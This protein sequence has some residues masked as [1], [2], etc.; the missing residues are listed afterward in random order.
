MFLRHE[1]KLC[2][3]S[4]KRA[5]PAE[6]CFFIEESNGMQKTLAQPNNI[7][8]GGERAVRIGEQQS[9]WGFT[10]NGNTSL[11]A[12][13]GFYGLKVPPLEAEITLGHYLARICGHLRPGSRVAIG[14]AELKIL[15]VESGAVRKV[16]LEFLPA[17]LPQSRRLARGRAQR[18][19]S[20]ERRSGEKPAQVYRLL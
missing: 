19:I 16:G 2:S 4:R 1:T 10:L 13:A 17:T 11:D 20:C 6:Q 9:F 7:V 14:G 12:I 18:S 3:C 15:E 5:V 8:L